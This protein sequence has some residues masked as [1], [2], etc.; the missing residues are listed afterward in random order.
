MY[1][2]SYTAEVILTNIVKNKIVDIKSAIIVPGSGLVKEEAEKEGLD[3]IFIKSGFEW[4][5]PRL[6]NVLRYER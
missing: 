2:F 1:K 6:L 3:K 4:R 5:E